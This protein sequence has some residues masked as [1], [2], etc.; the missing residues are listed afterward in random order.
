ATAIMGVPHTTEAI[1]TP[2]GRTITAATEFTAT[3]SITVITATNCVIRRIADELA[4][5]RFQASFFFYASTIGLR[6]A[7]SAKKILQ[8]C[9][10]FAFQNTGCDFASVI[11]RRHLQEVHHASGRACQCVSAAENHAPDSS[12]HE[13]AR[14][15][16]TRFF[17]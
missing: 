6:F 17:G 5:K 15:H 14:A 3:T 13:R 12:V 10:T 7:A 9:C 4:W 16:C 2:G 1:T 8:N 11:Q